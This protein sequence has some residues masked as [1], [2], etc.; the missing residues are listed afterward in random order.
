MR[1]PRENS[2]EGRVSHKA[3]QRG[4][5]K[6]KT[7]LGELDPNAPRDKWTKNTYRI[8]YRALPIKRTP[9]KL[10]KKEN[11]ICTDSV[12]I[13]RKLQFTF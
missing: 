1:I 11:S 12:I 9:P 8:S 13:K 3:E 10:G 5:K 6:A 7:M 2:K 4:L